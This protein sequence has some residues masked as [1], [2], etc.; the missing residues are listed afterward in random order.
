MKGQNYRSIRKCTKQP[1][2]F[3]HNQ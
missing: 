2:L 3:S 1:A